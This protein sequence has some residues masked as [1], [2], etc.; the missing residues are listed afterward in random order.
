MPSPDSSLALH[1]PLSAIDQAN[2]PPL[3]YLWV[4]DACIIS[5]GLLW[6][7]AYVLYILQARKDKSYGM[8]LVALCANIG[9]ELAYGVFYPLS[10]IETATFLVWVLIDCGIAHATVK[11]GPE[12]WRHAPLV[13]R[14]LAT[15][16]GVGCVTSLV[17]HC[18]FIKMF[19]SSTEAAFWSGFACQ[20]LLG[21]L[22]IIHIVSRG[23][24]SGHSRSIWMCRW[25]GSSLAIVVFS[26]RYYNYPAS[27]P[28]VDSPIAMSMFALTQLIDIVYIFVYGSIETQVKEKSQ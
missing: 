13:G 21:V 17:A 10:Y 6:T 27:Y 8:P 18:E 4:Q 23:N 20:N 14:N 5:G 28:Y 26:W 7:V 9:W 24:T 2:R 1:L 19:A 22:S 3:H 25:V 12:Q 16:I 15:V 11:S